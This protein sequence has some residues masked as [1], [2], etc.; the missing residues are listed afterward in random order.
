MIILA[1]PSISPYLSKTLFE[2]GEPAILA[3]D[4]KV[5]M[6]PALRIEPAKH[7]FDKPKHAY[8]SLILTSS[9]NALAFLQDAIPH[10]DRVLKARLFKDKVAFR[11]S[12]AKLYPEFYFKETTVAD[13]P[14]IDA[15]TLRFPLVIK[16]AA[17]ISSIGVQRVERAA[18]WKAAIDFLTKDLA[19][20][21]QNYAGVVVDA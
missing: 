18:D 8:Q 10:D 4:I 21:A 11:R 16:P 9:E 1:R 15:A 13:L 19:T 2:L 6:R 7:L 3:E 5:P 12:L 20:Y 14:K 17:G